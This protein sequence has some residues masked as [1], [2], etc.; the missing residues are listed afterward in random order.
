[1]KF[2]VIVFP[3]SSGDADCYHVVKEVIGQEVDYVWHQDQKFP[4]DYDCV[5]LPGGYSYGNYLRPGSIARFSPI[6]EEVIDF[7][8]QGGLVL[9]ISNGF[10]ILTEAGLLPGSLISNKDL[11]FVCKDVYLRVENN[12]TPFTTGYSLGQAIKMPVAHG[13]G[14]YICDQETL[15]KLK[16]NN[17]IIFRYSTAD[18]EVS[19]ECNF[20]GSTDSIAGIINEKGNVLGMMPHPERCAEDILGNDIGKYVFTSVVNWIKGGQPSGK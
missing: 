3:G 14:A 6:M 11:R 4:K 10:Q 9:G 12:K 19:P 8:R 17:Q 20:N 16:E 5:I 15:N 7:A 18:G 1:M 13:E 2:A